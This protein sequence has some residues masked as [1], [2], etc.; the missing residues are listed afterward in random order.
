MFFFLLFY[1]LPII[2][3]SLAISFL[4]FYLSSSYYLFKPNNYIITIIII[5]FTIIVIII[6]IIIIIIVII[7]IIIVMLINIAV[8]VT[9]D[10]SSGG[11]FQAS[12]SSG[13]VYPIHHVK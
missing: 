2:Y 6:I 10:K 8:T 3:L 12:N 1:H 9:L 7:I 4:K 11:E 13:T 5:L